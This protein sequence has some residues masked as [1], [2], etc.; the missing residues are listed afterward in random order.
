MYGSVPGAFVIVLLFIIVMYLFSGLAMV[1]A[2]ARW[3]QIIDDTDGVQQFGMSCAYD[4]VRNRGISF[5]G[6]YPTY[7][8]SHTY[9]W[10]GTTWTLI[11]S[12]GPPALTNAGMVFDSSRERIVLFG[13]FVTPDNYYG[14]T[15]EWDGSQWGK[16]STSGPGPRANHAMAYDASRKRVVLFGGSHYQT[17]YGD[18]WE[19]DGISWTQVSSEGPSPRIFAR[20][21]YD[22]ARERVVLFGG[23]THYYGTFLN[24]TWE[25]DGTT[26]T[27]VAT[28]GPSARSWHTMGYDPIRERVV[29][30]GGGGWGRN[31]SFDDTW[32][33]DGTSWTQVNES[34]PSKRIASCMFFD[35]KEGVIIL[36]G[37]Y[38]PNGSSLGD[39]WQYFEPDISISPASLNFGYVAKGDSDLEV[40]TISNVGSGTLD[41]SGMTLSD[42][43]NYSLD[44]NGGSNPCGSTSPTI[45]AEGNCTISILFTPQETGTIN[46]SLTIESDDADTPETDVSLTGI[47][48]PVS[49]DDGQ[50]G[51]CFIATAAYGSYLHPHVSVLREF[52]DDYLLTNPPG[53]AFVELYYRLSPP[54][55]DFIKRHEGLRAITRGVLAP[56]VYA[57]KYPWGALLLLSVGALV[58]PIARR[59]LWH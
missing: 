28:T 11:A 26:W 25:W 56:I 22:E 57:V 23:Q 55:A 43:V 31:E 27:K 46:A 17:I 13:G 59:R 12:D 35:R 48:S 29:L 1:P 44:V 45:T 41:V 6:N 52:R 51:N 4:R 58:V 34:G 33:W 20:M 9:E 15:W 8:H 7:I 3:E 40:L 50:T 47:S 53:R 10:D 5:G 30:F 54:L 21:V 32:E 18:T 39:T 36:F 49:V 38:V 37:G 24:D 42:T 16:V 14:D 19:W 2:H